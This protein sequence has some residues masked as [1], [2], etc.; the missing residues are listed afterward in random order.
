MADISED[1]A[2][3]AEKI[4][5]EYWDMVDHQMGPERLVEY[6]ADISTQ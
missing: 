5:L 1:N 3:S 4:E 2:D 6:A